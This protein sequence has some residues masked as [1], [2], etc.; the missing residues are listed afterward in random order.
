[1]GHVLKQFD[2][3]LV[4]IE[5]FRRALPPGFA[6]RVA[7]RPVLKE[8]LKRVA[9]G[10]LI[11]NDIERVLD[12]AVRTANQSR[13]R[14]PGRFRADAVLVTMNSLL[15][16]APEYRYQLSQPSGSVNNTSALTLDFD[17]NRYSFPAQLRGVLEAMCTRA[18]FRLSELPGG[19]TGEGLI[20]LAGYLQT[21]GFLT[22]AE[23]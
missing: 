11:D 20:D 17:G 6:S 2:P 13:R 9:P 15:R 23:K 19:L 14:M 12:S 22:A 8:Q 7:L 21:I 5:E 18:S 4:R 3:P 1:L 16:R 10:R